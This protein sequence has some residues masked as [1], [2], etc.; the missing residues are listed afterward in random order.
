M[1]YA[2]PL[3]VPTNTSGERS[4]P[5]SDTTLIAA[6]AINDRGQI[7]GYGNKDGHRA[8]FLLTSVR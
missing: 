1:S 8:A 4:A 7:A 6:T 5:A 3:I 2:Y